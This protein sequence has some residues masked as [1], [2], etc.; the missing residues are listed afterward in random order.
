M[1]VTGMNMEILGRI[2]LYSYVFFKELSKR[3]R[4]YFFWSTGLILII[5]GFIW[6]NISLELTFNRILAEDSQEY[7][8]HLVVSVGGVNI[9]AS[10]PQKVHEI[11]QTDLGQQMIE[12]YY[13]SHTL[14]LENLQFSSKTTFLSNLTQFMV[15][16]QNYLTL[17]LS[18]KAL[19]L[20]QGNISNNNDNNSVIIDKTT[21]DAYNLA[22]GDTIT[23]KHPSFNSSPEFTVGGII[24]YQDG[25][26]RE[27]IFGVP[28]IGIIGANYTL[29][30]FPLMIFQWSSFE[31]QKNSLTAAMVPFFRTIQIGFMVKY[32]SLNWF[33]TEAT[34]KRL[35]ELGTYLQSTFET[36]LPL[37]SISLKNNLVQYLQENEDLLN[38]IHLFSL[39]FL[40]PLGIIALYIAHL[41]LELPFYSQLSFWKRYQ[42]YGINNHALKVILLFFGAVLGLL[43]G[44][45]G[46]VVSIAS[47]FLFLLVIGDHVKRTLLAQY[48]EN[49][50]FVGLLAV[51]VFL[52]MLVSVVVMARLVRE[53]D[54]ILLI[55]VV[56][57]HESPFL[58]EIRGHN[59][60][61]LALSLVTFIFALVTKIV[62]QFSI[63]WHV[64][65]K[66]PLEFVSLY[67]FL[68]EL[69]LNVGLFVLLPLW[70][71][72]LLVV[73]FFN[74]KIFSQILYIMLQ[75]I[76]RLTKN[77]RQL[78]DFFTRTVFF[79]AQIYFKIGLVFGLV[80]SYLFIGVMSTGTLQRHVIEEEIWDVGADF[81]ID[82]PIT[83][84]TYYQIS[85]QNATTDLQNKFG[86]E[87]SLITMVKLRKTSAFFIGIDFNSYRK[88]VGFLIPDI[89]ALLP[90]SLENG[91]YLIYNRN[92]LGLSSNLYK[93]ASLT[94]FANNEDLNSNLTIKIRGF[95]T[96]LPGITNQDLIYR[97]QDVE[98]VFITTN[99]TLYTDILPHVLPLW[100]PIV[101][102]QN[103]DIEFYYRLL[104]R[105]RESNAQLYYSG[106]SYL[107][108]AV[109]G[110]LNSHFKG[111]QIRLLATEIEEAQNNTH[112]FRNILSQ[113]LYVL[114]FYLAVLIPF[115][116]LLAVVLIWR[117][118]RRVLQSFRTVGCTKYEILIPPFY[119]L[120]VTIFAV[121]VFSVFISVIT[122]FAIILPL[123]S[124]FLTPKNSVTL[125]PFRL[126]FPTN[127]FILLI[128][129]MF[130]TFIIILL[131]FMFSTKKIDENLPQI[132]QNPI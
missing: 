53:L 15:R 82:E 2:F 23:L 108:D 70:I 104:I 116:L 43:G 63:D 27:I 102:G 11:V 68:R 40:L 54:R 129:S 83:N 98:R 34:I 94:L 45:V 112:D 57:E 78:I 46:T 110:Y 96:K 72:M 28:E 106:E 17:L 131:G 18:I 122:V 80:L 66:I 115:L 30:I 69:T 86:V 73:Y 71:W 36:T 99:A 75:P 119:V 10:L 51:V 88:V 62:D 130:S 109:V 113:S 61:V 35:T 59:M 127:L 4:H 97:I 39:I 85:L 41:F 16:E 101:G 48:I 47:Y 32:T 123:F 26:T 126:V 77:Q 8:P 114:S 33:D 92:S 117:E 87:T 19:V 38:S 103:Y 81:A 6:L 128:I 76:K 37:A 13:L 121:L 74:T 91:T 12:R 111:A 49:V 67:V 56:K 84:F 64:P 55:E 21:A 132:W 22:L 90:H 125:A 25:W 52:N 105:Y 60:K 118:L 44:I 3:K 1:T 89:S 7:F 9:D 31:A 65:I 124:R 58:T 107:D 29:G 100:K 42:A 24:G 20:L 120:F 95:I 79:K 50:S 5:L 93:N 14:K